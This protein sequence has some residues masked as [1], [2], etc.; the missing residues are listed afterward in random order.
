MN[1]KDLLYLHELENQLFQKINNDWLLK[2]NKFPEVENGNFNQLPNLDAFLRAL[3]LDIDTILKPHIDSGIPWE[4]IGISQST[5][6]RIIIKEKKEVNFQRPTR[7]CLAYYL[8]YDGWNDFKFCNKDILPTQPIIINVVQVYRS[9]LPQK[10]LPKFLPPPNDEIE[11]EEQELQYEEIIQKQFWETKLFKF[12]CFGILLIGFLFF[13]GKTVS[14]WYRNRPFTEEQ[15]AKVK[16]EFVNQYDKPNTSSVKIHYDVSSLNTDSVSI[17]YGFEE[18]FIIRKNRT[19]NSYQY[20]ERFSKLEDTIAHTFFKPNVW[21]INL[22][23][24]GKIIRTLTKVVYTGH[25]WVSWS[26]G[27]EDDINWIGRNVLP[28]ITMNNGILHYDKANI[29]KNGWLA[30]FYTKHQINDDFKINGDS[31]FFEAKVKNNEME[32]GQPCYDTSLS[33]IDIQKRTINV[34]FV[35][36]C[37]EFGNVFLDKTKF[38]GREKVLPFLDVNLQVWNTLGVSVKNHKATLFVNGKQVFKT[39]YDGNVTEIKGIRITFRGS[40]SVDWVKLS[41][42]STEKVV[43]FDDFVRKKSNKLN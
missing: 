7:N 29:E 37:I 12:V 18:Y 36:D 31:V 3:L 39:K 42:S 16:F 41:N 14:S 21:I 9:L 27:K 6:R 5:L 30:F 10:L 26:S 34:N 17:D 2:W 24:K 11:D 8:G 43:F 13:T 33:L 35:Q 38:Y 4:N 32:G 20:I 19:D 1:I 28:Q 23:V 15:L 25:E 40:G 22:I